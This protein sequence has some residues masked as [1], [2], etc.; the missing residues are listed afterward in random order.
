M[1]L[2]TAAKYNIF[3]YQELKGLLREKDI[4]VAQAER[5]KSILVQ[6]TLTL[7]MT[8]VEADAW[9]AA[10]KA[11][12]TNPRTASE[13]N[14]EAGDED[15]GAATE[16]DNGEGSS[17]GMSAPTPHQAMHVPDD[18]KAKILAKREKWADA[19][20]DQ[21]ASVYN[22][23]EDELGELEQQAININA[24]E[25]EHWKY[26]ANGYGNKYPMDYRRA[27]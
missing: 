8:V 10:H 15:D 18:L 22:P 2:M 12:T 24:Q 3:L 26:V 16:H 9:L 21:E 27:F 19:F 14:D 20:R 5:R 4:T 13:D 23:L 1:A 6:K 11:A 17:Q 25:F 7:N